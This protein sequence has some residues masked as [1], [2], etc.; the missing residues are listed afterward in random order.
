MDQLLTCA[1]SPCPNDIYTYAA[2]LADQIEH[3]CSFTIAPI[4]EL[5]QIAR[6][7]DADVVKI[8]AGTFPLLAGNYRITSVGASFGTTSGPKLVARAGTS[9]MPS[10]GNIVLTP[11]LTTSASR[12]LAHFFPDCLQK[13][14]ALSEIPS[15]IQNGDAPFG[16]VLNESVQ[17]LPR[18]GLV[19]IAD[20]AQMWQQGTGQALPLGLVVI[21]EQV[22]PALEARFVKEIQSSIAWAEQNPEQALAITKQWSH[23]KD[24]RTI[25]AHIA[26]FTKDVADNTPHASALRAFFKEAIRETI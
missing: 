22:S 14:A 16:I 24:T 26:A 11:G 5:N 18:Y 23:E 12:V 17:D 13:E 7:G 2:L 1:V 4:G 3:H 9:T 21:K 19:E 10:H 20:L 15:R 8:S 25:E 6:R